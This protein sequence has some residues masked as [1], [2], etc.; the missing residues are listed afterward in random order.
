MQENLSNWYVRLSRRRFWKGDY[1]QDKIAA[2]QT[3]HQCLWV[4]AK[5]MAPIAP[6]FA[7]QLYNNLNAVTAKEDFESVHLAYFPSFDES[8]VN[9]PLEEKMQAAQKIAS[10]VLSIRQKE[11][12]KVRQPLK[13]VM[14]P[15]MSAHQKE[16]IEAVADL[17]KSEVN[18]KS[19]ELM[20]DASEILVKKIKPNFKTLGPKYGREMKSI[21]GAIAKFTQ[22]DIAKIE[23]EDEISVVVENK[24]FILGLADV[25]ISSQDIE[26][27][28]VASASGFTVALDVTIDQSLKN[29][30]I[31]REL[32]NRIQNM[33]KDAGFEVT[34]KIELSIQ[35][36]GLVEL[37]IA[38][39][40]NY[41]MSETLATDLQLLDV[42]DEGTA[43]QFDEVNTK[44]LIKK[45]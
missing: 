18:V 45:R 2:Y 13:R 4:T 16:T 27:W 24:T 36:D 29:E 32:V 31:A 9:K 30:G 14:I 26:G 19:V 5:L 33:R 22:E 28:L 37:A 8:M 12:I 40:K 21:A 17:I 39:N 15:V 43:V 41:L 25:E 7:D 20:D 35:N 1:G 11:K 42:L 34:D 10:L 23:R 38:D 44:L 6:F 3:L